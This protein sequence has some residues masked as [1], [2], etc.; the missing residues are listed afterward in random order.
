MTSMHAD[1]PL[2]PWLPPPSP[3][4]GLHLH[5]DS[6]R[7]RSPHALAAGSGIQ[8]GSTPACGPGPCGHLT[9]MHA[10]IPS[11]MSNTCVRLHP[12]RTHARQGGASG[13]YLLD[14]TD[15]SA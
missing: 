10:Y 12:A 2:D 13:D 1:V 14:G 8:V 9:C 6:L 15:A 5:L 7:I 11:L 4:P 3:P